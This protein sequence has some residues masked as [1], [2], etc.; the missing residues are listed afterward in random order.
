MNQA[1]QRIEY[2]EAASLGRHLDRIDREESRHEAIEKRAE[3]QYSILRAQK[4]GAVMDAIQ[5]RRRPLWDQIDGALWDLSLELAERV[6]DAPVE[7]EP[8]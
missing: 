1:A 5:E 7:Y 8:D 2:A 6:V 4:I 3:R